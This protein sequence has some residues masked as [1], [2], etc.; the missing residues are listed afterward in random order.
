M[1]Q[2]FQIHPTHPQPRLVKR[3]VEIVRAGGVIVYPTDSSYA[4]GCA[5][6]D[7]GAMERI[8]RI[9]R[10]DDDHHFTLVCR[11]LSELSQYARVTNADYRVLKAAT[12]GAYT[13]ILPATREVPRRLQHP[14][15]KTIGLRVP[16]HVIAQAL[17]AELG[18][19]LMSSTLILPGE[20]L[21][22]SD[23]EEIR[24]RLEHDV[25]LVL[26]GGPCGLEP[27]TVVVLDDGRATVVRE[28]RGSA[29]PFSVAAARA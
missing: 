8:R 2:Y 3:A 13:F 1:A 12:P 29:A 7:K 15:R 24:E 9:R 19:P 22:T 28:G 26:D 5:L 16:D 4:L 25:D 6:G 23:P 10:V 18:E 14:K 11:D 27:T 21:P 17:L 20:L